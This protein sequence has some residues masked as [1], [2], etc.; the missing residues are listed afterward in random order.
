LR[1]VTQTS[2]KII[3]CRRLTI[4]ILPVPAIRLYPNILHLHIL[5]TPA[6]DP[7]IDHVRAKVAVRVL[8]EVVCN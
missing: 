2:L 7:D 4:S 6:N 5:S 1:H 3:P 8:K